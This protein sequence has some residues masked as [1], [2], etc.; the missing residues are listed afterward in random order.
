[1]PAAFW[2]VSTVLVRELPVSRRVSI[3]KSPSS[4]SGMN[5]PPIAAM[6]P[7]ATTSKTTAATTRRMGLR[8]AL[9]NQVR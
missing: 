5:S 4:S 2:Q 8:M 1:M 6:M 3:A 7:P 9:S